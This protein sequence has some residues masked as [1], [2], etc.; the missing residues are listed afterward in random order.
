MD[1][2]LEECLDRLQQLRAVFASVGDMLA[3]GAQGP[4]ARSKLFEARQ[5]VA[6]GM[7]VADEVIDEMEACR[8]V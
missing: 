1:L 2:V 5:L 7:Q 3:A 8:P 4:V 6:L